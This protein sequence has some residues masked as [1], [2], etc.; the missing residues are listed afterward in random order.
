MTSAAGL[1]R[2]GGTPRQDGTARRRRARPAAT[3]RI[4]GSI[5]TSSSLEVLRNLA[6]LVVAVASLATGCATLPPPEGRTATSALADTADTRLGRAVTPLVAANPGRTGV[7][8]LPEP[9]DAFA[10]RVLLAGAAEKSLDVQYYIWHGDEVGYLLFEALWQAA[11]RGVRVRLLL[12]DHNT[13]GLDPTIA[14]LDAHPNLEVRLYNPVVQ[15]DARALNF[16]TDFARVN[17]RMHNKSFT[18]DNQV[19]VVGGRNIGNEYFGAGTGVV[20]ADLDVLVVGPSVREVSREFDLYWNSPSAYPAAGFVG[21][22]APDAAAV[23]AAK[24]AANARRP[25]LRRLHRGGA[26]D[27]AAAR[28]PRSPPAVRMDDGAAGVRRSGQDPRHRGEEGRA[29]LPAAGADDRPARADVRPR[30]A[31]LRAR[32]RRHRRLAALAASGV[33]VRILTNSLAASDEKVRSLRLRQ[34]ARGPAPR[35]RPAVRAQADGGKGGGRRPGPSC[36]SASAGLHAKTFAVD[37]SRIFVGSF[38]FDQRSALLNTEMGLVIDSPTLAQRLAETFD[39]L[40]PGSRTRCGWRR[41]A[42]ACTGSSGPRPASSVSTPSRT[43]AG[44]CAWVSRC[45]RY[46]R[47]SGCSSRWTAAGSLR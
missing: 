45:C 30:L 16:L 13:A 36:R 39:T 18:A 28:H 44:R 5:F 12:D 11:E 21:A 7:H 20:F 38:N 1:P 27:A 33:R 29:A 37:R 15:R 3:A 25:G 2:P 26:R 40:V 47:S 17:R 23:L 31:V 43:P 9:H 4:I 10:A 41:T 46:C 6:W 8:A 34:A 24:F 14:A 22:P 42:A 19:T 35:G 32:R